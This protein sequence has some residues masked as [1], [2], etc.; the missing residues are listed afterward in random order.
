MAERVG[1]PLSP[2]PRSSWGDLVGCAFAAAS[3]AG[4]ASCVQVAAGNRE[5]GQD[6][7]GP[8]HP[9]P[10][11]GCSG[12]TQGPALW[13]RP[14]SER[15]ERGQGKFSV[16]TPPRHRSRPGIAC[17][18]GVDQVTRHPRWEVTASPS[19]ASQCAAWGEWRGPSAKRQ[20]GGTASRTPPSSAAPSCP[21]TPS[22]APSL[23]YFLPSSALLCSP[24]P[25]CLY[26]PVP[27][28]L[29]TQS[30]VSEVG[31]GHGT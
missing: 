22:S 15:S 16:P 31:S 21:W 13:A 29:P 8:G 7:R 2:T 4:A 12:Q 19:A 23:A 20:N 6:M 27:G 14:L 30:F 28:Q 5:K 18:A 25:L 9:V 11:P 3:V 10:H 26:L 1:G 24:S 17:L